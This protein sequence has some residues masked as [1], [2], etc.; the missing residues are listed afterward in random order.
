ME[1]KKHN[2]PGDRRCNGRA[3]GLVQMVT[4]AKRSKLVD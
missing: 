4:T 2:F 3:M 1:A